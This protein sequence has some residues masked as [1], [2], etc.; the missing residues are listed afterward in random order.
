MTEARMA[1]IMHYFNDLNLQK[2]HAI[3]PHVERNS[4][5]WFFNEHLSFFL[6]LFFFR[7]W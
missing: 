6:I 2:Y 7:N 4:A 5:T 1:A 3:W